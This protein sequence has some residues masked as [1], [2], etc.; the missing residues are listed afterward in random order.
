MKKQWYRVK[1]KLD[2]VNNS[3]SKMV[4]TSTSSK[5]NEAKINQSKKVEITA[6]KS[7]QMLKDKSILNITRKWN[8]RH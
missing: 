1:I 8:K 3:K 5:R 6:V 7:R 4:D 2:E